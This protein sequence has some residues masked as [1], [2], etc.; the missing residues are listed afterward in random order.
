M[1]Y[2]EVAQSCPTFVTL[3]TIAYQAPPS[4]G[5]SRTEYW[6]GLPFRF[7]GALPD[8]G[9][10]PGSPALEA[11]SVTSE[12]P[13]KPYTALEHFPPGKYY[14]VGS[15]YSV[16]TNLPI[17]PTFP[18]APLDSIHLFFVRVSI[19]ALQIGSSVPFF[20]IPHVCINTQYFSLSD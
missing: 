17:H 15:R 16:S 13:G 19:S 4:M 9:I 12:P 5:F 10:E 1:L 11:D 2:S 3:W 14:T 20:S 7:P 8:P 18:L 6:S